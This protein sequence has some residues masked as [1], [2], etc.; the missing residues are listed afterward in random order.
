MLGP[1]DIALIAALLAVCWIGVRAG[2]WLVSLLT[3]GLVAAGGVGL[4]LGAP[5]YLVA[6]LGCWLVLAIVLVALWRKLFYKRASAG[7]KTAALMVAVGQFA[8]IAVLM[9]GAATS[10]LPQ[11]LDTISSASAYPLI[12]KVGTRLGVQKLPMELETASVL[13]FP[14]PIV[15]E[16][17]QEPILNESPPRPIDWAEV[18]RFDNAI[19]RILNGYTVPTDR[20]PISFEVGGTVRSVNVALGETFLAGDVLAELDPTPLQIALDQ[21]RAALIEAQATTREA[22]LSLDR[23]R[24][25]RSSGTISHAALDRAVAAAESAQS[26]L[27][28]V[29]AAIRQAEDRLSDVVLRAPFDG[30]VDERLIEPAQTIQAGQRAFEIQNAHS[31]FQIEIV[32][33]ETLIEK[34][35]A[36]VEHE[37]ALLNG[38]DH[39]IRARVHEIGSRAN[40]TNGFPVTLDIIGDHAFVRAG[41]TVEVHF[42]LPQPGGNEQHIGLATVPYTA[43]LPGDHDT[44]VSFVFNLQ[45]GRLERREITVVAREGDTA[46][47]SAGL[48]PGDIVATRGLPFLNDGE[49]VSLRG[50]GIARYDN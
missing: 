17:D 36:G 39:L 43:I 32:V 18:Y 4:Y 34:I 28:M 5:L 41:M 13:R 10:L 47:I 19:T 2:F 50:V 38:S 8:L 45:S 3:V 46:L 37:A 22:T 31:G 7:S 26:R 30:I 21:Q 35:E 9:T 27:E 29:Q 11:Q 6:A 16:P 1:Y 20:A 49:A 44:H 40:A 42:T 33:P 24:Q 15:P 12:A 25:L 14:G 48:E 23:Q